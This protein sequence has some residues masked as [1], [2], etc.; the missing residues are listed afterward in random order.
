ME[1]K[2]VNLRSEG[3][4]LLPRRAV[5][6]SWQESDIQRVAFGIELRCR[7]RLVVRY[8]RQLRA[9]PYERH[10]FVSE[11]LLK[12]ALNLLFESLWVRGW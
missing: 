8:S 7:E 11:R 1:V 9:G 3:H 4:Q 5:G 2:V 10:H 12:L 6:P